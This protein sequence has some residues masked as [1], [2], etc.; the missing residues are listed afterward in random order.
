MSPRHCRCYLEPCTCFDDAKDWQSD[1]HDS[2]RL[3]QST[4]DNFLAELFG[5]WDFG[6]EEKSSKWVFEVPKKLSKV[7]PVSIYNI[8]CN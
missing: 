5:R 3:T 8:Q 7:I 6:V 4:V 1:S 2:Y